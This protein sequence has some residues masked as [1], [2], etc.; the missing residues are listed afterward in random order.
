MA[1]DPHTYVAVSEYET[2][3]GKREAVVQHRHGNP[4]IIPWHF[5]GYWTLLLQFS[6]SSHFSLT[7]NVCFSMIQSYLLQ[8]IA[9]NE[10]C[11]RPSKHIKIV[12]QLNFF[13]IHS[14]F[15][16]F[17]IFSFLPHLH[18]CCLFL[19]IMLV[20][21]YILLCAFVWSTFTII[22]YDSYFFVFVLSSFPFLF[23]T[24]T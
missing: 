22:F 4:Y 10:V 21:T 16:L 12:A 5:L 17:F 15:I 6:R 3:C 2:Q 13:F 7:Y 20:A 18:Y 19:F 14:S 1:V 9:Q 8:S 24:I 23:L 11:K